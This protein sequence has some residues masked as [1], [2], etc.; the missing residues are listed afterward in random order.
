MYKYLVSKTNQYILIIA[1]VM[2]LVNLKSKM[3]ITI[4]QSFVT[5]EVSIYRVSWLLL[6]G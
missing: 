3:V 2:M 5:N 1:Y 6:Y 4:C